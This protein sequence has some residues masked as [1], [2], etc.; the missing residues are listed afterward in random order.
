MEYRG[1]SHGYPPYEEN[2]SSEDPGAAHPRSYREDPA[3]NGTDPSA[4]GNDPSP[5]GRD[6]SAYGADP[7]PY[8]R[9]PSAYGTDPSAY[10]A[11]PSPYGR[12]PSAYGTDPS[13]YGRDPSSYGRDP[14]PYGREEGG[15]APANAGYGDSGYT[16]RRSGSY[17]DEY[18]A[19]GGNPNTGRTYYSRNT[20][21]YGGDEGDDTGR[22]Y[23]ERTPRPA[24]RKKKRSKFA[25]F[26]RALGLYLAQLPAK[27][28]VV[29]GGSIAMVLVAI[30]LLAVLLPNSNRTGSSDDGQLAIADV[31]VTPSLAPTNTPAPTDEPTPTPDPDPLNGETIS[32]AGTISDLIPA[33]QERLVELGYMDMPEGG[34]TN[35]YGPST[36]TAIRLFQLKNFDSSDDWD[37]IIGASTYNL[38]MS[39]DAKAY[40]LSRGDGDDRT[41]ILTKLV[42]DITDLQNRLIELGYLTSGSATGYYGETTVTAVQKF[43]EYNGL[44][45][46]D[47]IAGQETLD[48]I[49]SDDA[50]D[51]VTGKANNKSKI[52]PTPGSSASITPSTTTTTPAP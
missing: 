17:G 36:K 6:P 27:T 31:T 45:Q 21:R 16:S 42:E 44:S 39:D 26:M 15:Y 34:Y 12:D 2:P 7:S 38:L 9:D 41:K 3:T 49:Y 13:P 28:L 19:R 46:I 25:R 51:A 22:E 5:Y 33:I 35:K 24:K 20:G 48:L 32:K 1:G 8:G 23:T 37:G 29:I 11:D 14:S 43:Q 10:G 40:Y 52:T 50:M 30:V 47:G 4:Y 18:A